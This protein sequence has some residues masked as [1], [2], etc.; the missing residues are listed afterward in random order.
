MNDAMLSELTALEDDLTVRAVCDGEP[1]G[2]RSM[3]ACSMTAL[4]WNGQPQG[5]RRSPQLGHDLQP[6]LR[7]SSGR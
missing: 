7:G 3:G 4:P 1:W 6:S 5:G 2:Y